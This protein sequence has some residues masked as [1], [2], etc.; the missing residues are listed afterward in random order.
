MRRT[1]LALLAATSMVSAPLTATSAPDGIPDPVERDANR[2]RLKVG[3]FL[4]LIENN[5]VLL[6]R[7]FQTGIGDGQ[8]VVPMGGLDEGETVTEAVI[9]EA[10]EEAN[11]VYKPEDLTVAHVMHGL[12]HFPT[13]EAFEQIHVF[14][15]AEHHD[16]VIKNMEPE[17]ADE[18]AFYSLDALP[19][20][21]EPF[22]R[23]ALDSIFMG[24]YFSEYGWG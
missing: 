7:R 8:Y 24:Q 11:L 19:P 4:V 9:R 14:F 23:Q 6:L 2:Y 10:R 15:L 22:I 17:K 13:G 20:Q 16:G 1:L 5:E 21:T 18:L 3:V 12:H